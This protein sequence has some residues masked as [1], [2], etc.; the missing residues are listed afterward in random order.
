MLTT[1]LYQL[2]KIVSGIVIPQFMIKSYGSSAYGA[3]SSITQFLSYVTLLEGGIGGVARAELYKPLADGNSTEI[4]KV[5][6]AVRRVFRIIGCVFL[7]YTVVLACGFRHITDVSFF[8]DDYTFCLVIAISISTIAQ[9]FFGIANLTL[10]NA[11]QK[12]YISNL[13]MIVTTA[14]NAL[15]VIILIKMGCDILT[16]KLCSSSIFILRPLFFS[17]YVKRH[18]RIDRT[19]KATGDVLQ[20]KWTGLGQHLAY[21]LHTNTDVAILTVF[22]DLKWVA[23][24]GVYNLVI[25]SMRNIISALT[26][27]M[28]ALFGEMI[29]RKEKDAL[30]S[31]YHYYDL[32]IS[33]ATL[34]LFGTTAILIVP[35]I[36]LYTKGVSDAEYIQPVF[37][38]VLLFAEAVNCMFLPCSMLP[39]AANKFKETRWAAYGEAAINVGLSCLLVLWNPLVGVAVATAV[40][41]LYKNI[42]YFAYVSKNIL[43]TT[44]AYGKRYLLYILV[45]AVVSV[46]GYGLVSRVE[47]NSMTAWVGYGFITFVCVCVVV[48]SVYTL[49]YGK[50]FVVTICRLIQR[51][52]NRRRNKA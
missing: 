33:C 52:V 39:V 31:T 14:L 1:L 26:G 41:V 22:A 48:F 20:Q 10:L 32:I 25:S 23:V 35:F 8:S 2:I 36:R 3:T 27:G 44:F 12:R 45:L 47:I 50:Q 51:F 7:G 17:V 9:Y 5:Y 21:Y 28:E 38:L 40:S 30:A 13:V 42:F 37:A 29:A 6:N 4:S 15:L 24:Y 16:V 49:V 19:Q 34:V 18:Y 46:G 11:D 43:H